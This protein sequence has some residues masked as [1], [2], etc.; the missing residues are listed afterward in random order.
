MDPAAADVI[1]REACVTGPAG[2]GCGFAGAAGVLGGLLFVGLL[3][4]VELPDPL[5]PAQN[6]VA[7][8]A[9]VP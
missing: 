8:N 5:H 2:T 7:A 4:S 1:V 3:G 6:D 9:T